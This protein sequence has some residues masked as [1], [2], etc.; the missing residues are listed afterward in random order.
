MH[1]NDKIKNK[2]DN[3]LH[4]V[5]KKCIKVVGSQTASIILIPSVMDADA[6]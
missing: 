6:L 1:K 2:N 3:I 5:D 4:K